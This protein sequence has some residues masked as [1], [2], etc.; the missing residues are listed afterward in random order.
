MTR[1]TAALLAAAAA[2]YSVL[3]SLDHG[4]RFFI[5]LVATGAAAGGSM[6]VASAIKKNVDS[7]PRPLVCMG[8]DGT[9]RLRV[10]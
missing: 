1:A 3:T 7:N 8:S 4:A 5:G 6:Y 2:V 9:Y 10:L